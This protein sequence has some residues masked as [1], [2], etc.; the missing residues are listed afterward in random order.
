VSHDEISR[1]LPTKISVW[2][3]NSFV[4]FLTRVHLFSSWV[5]V[6]HLSVCCVSRV[7]IQGYDRTPC[8]AFYHSLFLFGCSRRSN[9]H[10]ISSWLGPKNLAFMPLR[11]FYLDESA[12]LASSNSQIIPRVKSCEN[13]TLGGRKCS[14]SKI[15][16]I[17]YHFIK[18]WG[19]PRSKRLPIL[20]NLSNIPIPECNL[21]DPPLLTGCPQD[22]K[23]FQEEY[24]HIVPCP[25]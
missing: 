13:F 19:T 15:A 1:F 24:K 5:F 22:P 14:H 4:L 21:S 3:P 10:C 18:P 16:S 9:P 11:N 20:I 6:Q 23:E 8:K 25:V 12:I 2:F 7:Q 17:T